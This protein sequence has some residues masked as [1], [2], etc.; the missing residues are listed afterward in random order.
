MWIRV[1]EDDA[2]ARSDGAP[3]VKSWEQEKIT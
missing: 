3:E 2:H 1:I